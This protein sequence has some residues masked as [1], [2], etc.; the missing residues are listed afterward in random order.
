MYFVVTMVLIGVF[1]SGTQP[2]KPP[3]ALAT[4]NGHADMRVHDA[5]EFEL[6]GLISDEE[7]DASKR[8]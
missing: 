8:Q 3:A 6:E 1:T 5:Q 4:A 2:A 7:E